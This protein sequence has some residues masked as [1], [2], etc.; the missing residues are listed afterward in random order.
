MTLDSCAEKLY[1][2]LED[3]PEAG[4]GEPGTKATRHIYEMLTGNLK[5]HIMR[6]LDASA[7][8]QALRKPL[9][10]QY[11]WKNM[12]LRAFTFWFFFYLS[13]LWVQF[14]VRMEGDDLQCMFEIWVYGTLG[15]RLLD[16]YLDEK[17]GDSVQAIA[18]MWLIGEH[19]QQLLR[20]FADIP[21][22]AV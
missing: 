4:F 13:W 6:V 19:E 16:L 18:G 2:L 22:S 10:S 17:K 20:Y 15:Y 8:A 1:S 12:Y 3:F 14:G 5:E 7:P 11:G 21:T 9:I